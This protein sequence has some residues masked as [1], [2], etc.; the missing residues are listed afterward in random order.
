MHL[1]VNGLCCSRLLDLAKRTVVPCVKSEGEVEGLG[2]GKQ[3]DS[4]LDKDC[5]AYHRLG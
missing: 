1:K 2:G 4:P 3:V 5:S